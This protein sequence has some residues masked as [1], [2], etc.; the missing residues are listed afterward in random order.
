MK[1]IALIAALMLIS[2][3]Q[4]FAQSSPPTPNAPG[5]IGGEVSLA[6]TAASGTATLPAA[7]PPWSAITI[8]NESTGA[9]DAFVTIGLSATTSGWPVRAGKRIVFWVPA[10]TTKISAICGGTDT[11][12]LDIYQSTGF[13][14]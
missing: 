14:Q 5:V 1:K 11:T 6:V 7:T 13:I 2:T 4:A 9:K 10:G 12:T 8:I 3:Q